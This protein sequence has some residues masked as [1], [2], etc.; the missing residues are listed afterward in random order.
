M[1]RNKRANYIGGAAA[2]YSSTP[3]ETPGTLGIGDDASPDTTAM[4]GDTPGPTGLNDAG[5]SVAE[6]QSRLTHTAP[7]TL[8]R[9]QTSLGLLHFPVRYEAGFND[10]RPR[11]GTERGVRVTRSSRR[12]RRC[13]SV[14]WIY[15]DDSFETPRPHHGGIDIIGP[16]R[17]TI[18]A[19][20]AA[21][22]VGEWQ[23]GVM[24]NQA[25][26]SR[27]LERATRSSGVGRTGEGAYF[28]RLVDDDGYIHYYAHFN[29][30]PTAPPPGSGLPSLAA[31]SRIQAGQIIGRLGDTGARGIAH[32]HYQINSPREATGRFSATT[33][34]GTSYSS[35]GGGRVNPYCEL[36]HLCVRD[37][38]AARS[39]LKSDRYVIPPAGRTFPPP[40]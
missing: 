34:S 5:E 27:R 15:F 7:A 40:C 11:T 3:A 8:P 24:R 38:N 18:I 30:D 36:V 22:V 21:T 28:I 32:L 9:C 14:F 6:D 23:G 37:H 31:G 20:K 12:S 35:A 19:T 2:D 13:R 1:S 10:A 39:Q 29:D 17:S 25:D 16:L 26:G 4:P 33:P